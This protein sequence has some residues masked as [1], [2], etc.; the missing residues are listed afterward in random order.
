VSRAG[1]WLLSLLALALLP[2]LMPNAYVQYVI[3]SSLILAFAVIGL[4]IIFGYA[5]QH[6]FGFPVFFGVGGYASALLATAATFPVGLA[7]PFGSLI[8]GAISSV[9]GF[10]SFRLRGIYFGV[11]TIAFAYVIYIIAQNWVELTHGPMGIPLVPPLRLLPEGVGAVGRDMQTR[12]AVVSAIAIIIFALD[13]LLHS[14]IG[15]AWHAV[16][17]N[18]SLASSLGISPLHYQMAAFVLGA[19]ISGVGGG[20]Y[21][22]Y[23]GFI[24]PT[25]L[26]FHYIGV[27]FIMLIAGGT[28]TLSG[29]ILGS[30][31]FGVLPELLRVAE[32]ARN[33]LLGL[34]LLF[35]IVMVP[36]GLTGIWNRLRPGRKVPGETSP[37]ATVPDVAAEIVSPATPT[38]ELK[39]GGVFKSFEGLTA[40]SNVTF[41]VRPG[42]LV[43]LI[44]PNGAG[45]TTLF[46][47]ITGMLAPTGGNVSYCNREIGGLPPH[48]IAAFGVTRTYQITSLFPDLSTQE[49]I[50]VATHLR[51]CRSALAALLRSKRFRDSEEAIDKTVDRILHLVRLQSRRNL[52]A[53]ALSYGDQ[54]RLEIGLAL[55]TG[56]GLILL[57]EPA[58]GLNAEETDELCDLIRR[59]RSAG[60]TVIVIEHDM[61][62]VMGLCDRIVVLSLGRIIFDGTPKGAAA[63]PDVIEAYLGTETAYA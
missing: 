60:F 38:G 15:R 62:M 10:F 37:V 63:H 19:V 55:A 36:E 12:I 42:E 41:S 53:S 46:N 33:L 14:P 18:E 23:V 5:G 57:D 11:G 29:P 28:G 31:V 4:N 39:L 32:T 54:R 20:F 30:V 6:A 3:N 51:S 47:I 61:R 58:A 25:E 35:C 8:T 13:R 40:L 45:K 27:V 1:V 21:A 7:I 48:S 52:P 56:A 24:S 22:H 9:I 17:E 50:R 26:G 49:N 16:R 43:G 59:L 44:G 34:I 2:S